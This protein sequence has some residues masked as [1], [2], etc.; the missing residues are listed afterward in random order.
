M[1][2]VNL[3]DF[4]GN[5]KGMI[6]M[7]LQQEQ[8]KQATIITTTTIVG[9]DKRRQEKEPAH[10]VHNNYTAH[11]ILFHL[12]LLSVGSRSSRQQTEPSR[13]FVYYYF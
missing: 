7:L 6:I 13:S 8:Q 1:F 4:I 12:K 3:N 5:Y 11:P 2:T 9:A 10:L